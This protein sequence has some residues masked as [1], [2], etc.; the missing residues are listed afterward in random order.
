M[1]DIEFN[2][3]I[4]LIAG[5]NARVCADLRADWKLELK[6]IFNGLPRPVAMT[7]GRAI[8]LLR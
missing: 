7:F 8:G 3:D 2:V 5:A 4:Q 1:L 6:G